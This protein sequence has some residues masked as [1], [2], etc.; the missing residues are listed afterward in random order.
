MQTISTETI[1]STYTYIMLGQVSKSHPSLNNKMVQ[2]TLLKRKSREQITHQ[3]N[4]HLNGKPLEPILSKYQLAICQEIIDAHEK[5]KT[6]MTVEQI[7]E[8]VEKE[9]V[10]APY[11]FEKQKIA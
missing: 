10:N 11:E 9:K 7:T 2:E 4:L 5:D 6:K 1:Q 8:I 3:V